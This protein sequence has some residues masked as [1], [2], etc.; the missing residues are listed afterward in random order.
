MGAQE[1]LLRRPRGRRTSL[2]ALVATCE[3][4]GINPETYLADVLL[5]VQTHPKSRIGE[6]L[7]HEWM[8]RRAVDPPDSPLRPSP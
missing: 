5:R 3:T 8:R 1:Q 4:N 7:P 6:L 2:Y